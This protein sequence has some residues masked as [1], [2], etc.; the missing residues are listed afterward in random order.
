[1][2]HSLLMRENQQTV[3]E[4]LIEDWISKVIVEKHLLKSLATVIGYD[5]VALLSMMELR[6][7]CFELFN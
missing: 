5:N 4:Y 3:F 1:M 2:S 7:V 6:N